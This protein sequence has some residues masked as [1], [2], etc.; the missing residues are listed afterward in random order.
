MP[1]AARNDFR[2]HLVAPGLPPVPEGY[3]LVESRILQGIPHTV[4]LDAEYSLLLVVPTGLARA[5]VSADATAVVTSSGPRLSPTDPT[6]QEGQD[7][8]AIGAPA[9]LVVMRAGAMAGTLPLMTGL[10][11]VIPE[12]GTFTGTRIKVLI[13]EWEIRAGSLRGP[14]DVGSRIV[15]AWRRIDKAA[16]TFEGWAAA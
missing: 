15:L 3:T 1:G 2:R 8:L 16:S 7:G 11:M 14:G 13:L 6:V 10:S 9:R 12:A 5:W 4:A